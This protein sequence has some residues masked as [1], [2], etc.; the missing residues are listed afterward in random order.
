[1]VLR[2]ISVLVQL[3]FNYLVLHLNPSLRLMQV[4]EQS[5]SLMVSVHKIPKLI[6]V[7]HLL[8]NLGVS[9]K[10]I[11]LV[12]VLLPYPLELLR[13]DTTHQS[14]QEMLLL[15]ILVLE[16][17]S[18]ELMMIKDLH[19]PE[20]F[21]LSSLLVRSMFLV[22]VLQPMAIL[23][24]LNLVHLRALLPQHML[25]SVSL[26]SPE[27]QRLQKSMFMDSMEMM[28]IQELLVSS[29][30]LHRLHHLSRS[31]FLLGL[32]LEQYMS[33]TEVSK[34]IPNL[35]LDLVE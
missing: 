12:L 16:L 9:Q 27:L 24:V 14:T 13:Q 19:S 10:A 7:D 31:L 6:L 23:K 28:Q 3:V 18:S 20:R 22:L 32:V 17:D 33:Q 8:E 1:M 21:Y 4:L 2:R 25:E 30:F 26:I 29:Q 15:V 5:S 35:T 34:E 11:I